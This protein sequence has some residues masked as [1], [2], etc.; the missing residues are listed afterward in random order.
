MKSLFRLPIL[1]AI[2]IYFNWTFFRY[3]RRL[4]RDDYAAVVKG[5]V[6]HDPAPKNVTRSVAEYAREG[7]E[8]SKFKDGKS[9]SNN[10]FG[11]LGK[12][13]ALGPVNGTAGA[14]IKHTMLSSNRRG[15]AS[16]EGNLPTD[17]RSVNRTRANIK[18]TMMLASNRRGYASSGGKL[19]TDYQKSYPDPRTWSAIDNG[20]CIDKSSQ[21]ASGFDWQVRAPHAILLGVMKGGT[22]ALSEY[23][24]D[25][26]LVTPPKNESHEFHFFDG[27]HFRR[28]KSGIP[29]KQ[30]QMAYAQRV[31]MRYPDFFNSH[32]NGK[33]YTIHD[34]PRYLLWSDRIPDAILCVTPWAKLMAVLRDPV[35]RVI[36]HYRFQDEGKQTIPIS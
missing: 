19:P 7:E 28:D 24:W 22:H 9:L 26:P 11:N 1:V 10:H 31:Q 4:Q 20:T 14:N 34:S 5:S 33:L 17:Y 32:S 2:V 35:E 12:N 23:L 25:H 18:H 6:D 13:I 36:S 3:A 29:Q 21:P 8:T 15:Y 27:K 30:N 16:S